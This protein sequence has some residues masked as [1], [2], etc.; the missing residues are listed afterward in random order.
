[1]TI[2]TADR[3]AQRLMKPKGQEMDAKIIILII[4]VVVIGLYITYQNTKKR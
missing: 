3:A 1:M 2:E 4:V